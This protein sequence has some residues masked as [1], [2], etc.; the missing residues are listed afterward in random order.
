MLNMESATMNRSPFQ[1]TGSLG[2]IRWFAIIATGLAIALATH[3]VAQ[4]P[5]APG[6]AAPP[7]SEEELGKRVG[8]IAL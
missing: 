7:A 3:S 1:T 8:P 5:A 4:A 2:Q 6:G